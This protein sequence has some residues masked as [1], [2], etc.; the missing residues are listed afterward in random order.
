MKEPFVLKW[1]ERSDVSE[2]RESKRDER[3]IMFGCIYFNS[4]FFGT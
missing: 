1:Y 2:A 3:E 4:S